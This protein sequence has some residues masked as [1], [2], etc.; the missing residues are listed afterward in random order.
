MQKLL[1]AA[2]PPADAELP[3]PWVRSQNP[4]EK[5]SQ[6]AALPLAELTEMENRD[7]EGKGQRRAEKDREGQRR[8]EKGIEPLQAARNVV[9]GKE[10][11]NSR[12]QNPSKLPAHG[13]VVM[14]NEKDNS[15]VHNSSKLPA[16]HTLSTTGTP[17]ELPKAP[18][19]PKT[20]PPRS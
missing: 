9:V 15:R 2:G 18:E 12:V 3:H 6:A 10:K 7:G 20:S 4:Q 13:N 14:G 19:R 17:A 5:V 11:D 8:A 16:P 1:V